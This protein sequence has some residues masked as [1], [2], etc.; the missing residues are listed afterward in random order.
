MNQFEAYEI[1]DRFGNSLNFSPQHIVIQGRQNYGNPTINYRETRGFNQDGLT[2]QSYTISQRTL[3]FRVVF[4]AQKDDTKEDYWEN[5]LELL[6]F[7]NPYSAPLKFRITKG[8]GTRYELREVWPTSGITMGNDITMVN[9][10]IDEAVSITAK[11]PIWYNVDGITDTPS[12]TVNES[13]VFPIDFPIDFGSS[14][15]IFTTTISNYQGNYK[16]YPKITIDGGYNTATITNSWTNVSIVLFQQVLSGQW[17]E[18][19]LDP[20]NLYIRDQDGNNRF[21]EL[22]IGS[23][24]QDFYIKPFESGNITVSLLNGNVDSGVTVFYEER[25]LGI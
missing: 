24:L 9:H 11:D 16:S 6:S 1:I 20:A 13:L 10:L 2:I 25:Y 4:P 15:R 21:D 17:R 5:R 23:N 12:A 3:N 14:G 19:N 8:D 7:F 22:T 18:I